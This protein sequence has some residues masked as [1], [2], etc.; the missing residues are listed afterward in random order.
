MIQQGGVASLQPFIGDYTLEEI[1]TYI[2]RKWLGI[3]YRLQ[4]SQALERAWRLRVSLI[5]ERVSGL[6]S[7]IHKVFLLRFR[8]ERETYSRIDR[9]VP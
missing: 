4:G 5:S 9:Q 7:F 3:L 8:W 1:I 2:G 6:E